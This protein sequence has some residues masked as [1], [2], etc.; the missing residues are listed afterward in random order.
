[1]I[2]LDTASRSLQAS[3]SPAPAGSIPVLVSFGAVSNT[4]YETV[5]SNPSAI[6]GTASVVILATDAS[7]LQ[8]VVHYMS[9]QNPISNAV[10]T[11]T[12]SLVDTGTSLTTVIFSAT[13]SPGDTLQYTQQGGFVVT[14]STGA[15]K[16]GGGGGGITIAQGDGRYLQ[17]TNQLKA[18][19]TIA[20][21]AD[22]SLK[23]T[24]DDGTFTSL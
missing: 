15:I 8:R 7:G 14:D 4:R 17:L 3:A 18:N 16:T 10:E 20:W 2:T 19:N 22:G 1:M 23:V 9:F 6:S 11:V 13:L 12:I 24:H 21:Q 5:L